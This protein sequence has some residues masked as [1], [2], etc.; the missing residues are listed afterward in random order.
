MSLKLLKQLQFV[1]TLCTVGASRT[2][3]GELKCAPKGF[4]S[5]RP[6]RLDV[7]T[8]RPM[9]DAQRARRFLDTC[10]RRRTHHMCHHICSHTHTQ[11]NDQKYMN[12]TKEHILQTTALFSTHSAEITKPCCSVRLYVFHVMPYLQNPPDSKTAGFLCPGEVD[13]FLQIS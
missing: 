6:T 8:K 12:T 7:L 11:Q 1:C 4:A 10:S 2:A 3:P 5:P 9:E 13:W